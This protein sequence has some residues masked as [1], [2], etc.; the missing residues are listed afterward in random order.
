MTSPLISILSH[1]YQNPHQLPPSL[2]F[3]YSAG[4][5]PSGNLTSVLFFDRLR[6]LFAQET[7]DSNRSFELF[8]TNSTLPTT[9]ASKEQRKKY[10][11]EDFADGR[12]QKLQY[13]RLLREDLINALGP[14]EGRSGTVAYVC[15]PQALTDW[16]VDRMSEAEGMQKERV[17]CEKWW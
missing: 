15:G 16:A 1:L 3:L 5:G 10:L 12:P 9:K 14:V 13:R 4:Q 11:S 7:P 17:L 8:V 6:G 2:K